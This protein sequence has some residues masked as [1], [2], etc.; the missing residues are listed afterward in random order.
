MI[1]IHKPAS[2]PAILTTSGRQ[3]TKSDHKAFAADRA[4]FRSGASKF[5]FDRGI[6]AADE[7]KI[8]LRTAQH[9]KCAFCEAKVTHITDGDIEHFRPKSAVKQNAGGKLEYPGYFWLAYDWENLL[10]ACNNCNRRHK[11]NLFPLLDPKKRCRPHRRNLTH[12]SPL[13]VNPADEDPAPFLEFVGETVIAR[14]GNPR[15]QA[16]IDALGLD[17]SEL[18]NHRLTKLRL[19]QQLQ[20]ALSELQSRSR[21]TRS[22]QQTIADIQALLAEHQRDDAEYSAMAQ[23]FLH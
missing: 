15:G 5:A 19:L 16:T 20:Q 2:P 11:G 21:P 7:V 12:E 6:Y 14:G 18:T 9:D 1:R 22:Q 23:A 13:F 8:A 17:R 3:Q 4:G 10:L